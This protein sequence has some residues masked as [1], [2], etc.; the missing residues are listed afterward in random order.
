MS[1][2]LDGRALAAAV[3]GE[4][5]A[6]VASLRAEGVEPTLALVVAT[7]DDSAAWYV[8]ALTRSASKVG[9]RIDLVDLGAGA[10]E[11]EIATALGRLAADDAVHGI[12]LQTPLPAGVPLHALTSLI[13]PEQDV[14]GVNPLSAGRLVAGLPAFAPATAAAVMELL[15]AHDVPLEGAHVVVV[16]RS[17]IVG[18]PV[19]QLMLARNATVTVCHS[20]TKDLAGITRQADVLVAAIGRPR[21]LTREHVAKG[22]T[23]VDVGTTPDAD[24]KLVGDVDAADVDDVARAVSPVPGGVGPVTT[25]L[26]LR[27]TARAAA[28]A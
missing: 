26:L 10:T 11:A 16:G 24:G 25:A 22:A 5:S 20:R 14:D 15:D 9:L 13:P 28:W 2:I 6:L 18:K 21:F 7:D 8:R 23:V 12:I 19:A 1:A 4:T 17:V 3:Q 27:N